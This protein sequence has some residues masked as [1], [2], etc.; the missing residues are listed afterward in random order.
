M[1]CP[2][3]P[4]ITLSH[5]TY[6][7][8]TID[9]CPNCKGTWLDDGELIQIIENEEKKFGIHLTNETLHKAFA[10]IPE[11]EQETKLNCPTCGEH[12][13]AVNYVYDSGVIVDRCPNDHGVW[14]DVQ[15]L[16]KVQIYKEEWAKKTAER[17]TELITLLKDVSDEHKA[18]LEKQEEEIA[19]QYLF[20]SAIKK[21]LDLFD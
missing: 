10:G 14:L 4:G 6:E 11:L 2:R 19:S 16:E 7:G 13:V 3:C 9:R 8:V 18:N 20:G 21:V 1:E 15:E 17:Q 12:M 5:D